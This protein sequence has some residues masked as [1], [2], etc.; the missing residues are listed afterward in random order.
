MDL[1]SLLQQAVAVVRASN[2][3]ISLMALLA[4]SVAV[5][6]VLRRMVSLYS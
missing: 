5:I 2:S 3:V 6:A 4:V 1:P